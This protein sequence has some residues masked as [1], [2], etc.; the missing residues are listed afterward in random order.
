MFAESRDDQRRMRMG[1]LQQ[2]RK[3]FSNNFIE[4]VVF[5][6]QFPHFYSTA[7]RGKHLQKITA[8]KT[9]IFASLFAKRIIKTLRPT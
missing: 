4:Y 6:S 8:L 2:G 9:V 5:C 1:K 7:E 3:E